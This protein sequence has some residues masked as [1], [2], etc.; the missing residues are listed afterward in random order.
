MFYPLD[1]RFKFTRC[2]RSAL[3]LVLLGMSF[4]QSRA[5]ETKEGTPV[6]FVYMFSADGDVNGPRT[7]CEHLR[8]AVRPSAAGTSISGERQSVCD[9][10]LNVVAGKDEDPDRARIRTPIAAAKLVVDS[11]QRVLITEPTTGMVHILDFEKR[12]YSRIDGA[13][14]DRMS[15]PYG[16]AVDADNNI[17]VTDLKRGRIAVY[18]ADGKFKGYI[19]NIKGENLFENPRS[20]AIDRATGRIY[21]A[22]SKRNFVII[23]DHGGKIL[24][25]IGKRGGGVDP[26][27]FKGPTEITVYQNEVFVLDQQNGRVQVLD[28][29]GKFRRQL[30]LRGGAASDASGM[31]V[32]SQGRLFIPVLNW[33]EVFG[34]EGQLL[35]RFGQNGNH[36]GEFQAPKGICTDSK[37]RVY[38]TDT[39]NFRIQVFQ[40]TD[41]PTSKT[42][43]AQ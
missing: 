21:V 30:H 15:V 14:G 6:K 11:N 37:D 7:P 18:N 16:I 13:K 32:D 5:A 17:Y 41:Q 25:Q 42:D 31:A 33:V 12:R 3:L 27:E 22:D 24:A 20:I 28:L 35:F 38:V 39:G 29:D 4:G 36:P 19:G 2:G 10:V 40:V 23:L 9:Q 8:D 1:L 34:R 43:A 26:A